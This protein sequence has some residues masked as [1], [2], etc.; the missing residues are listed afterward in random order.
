MSPVPVID[1]DVHPV[2]RSVHQL[3]PY[4][5]AYWQDFIAG[6]RYPDFRPLYHP[7]HSPI[8][9]RPDAR[10]PQD[11]LAGG[12]VD[13]LCA[14][15]L[16]DGGADAA[17]LHCLYAVQLVRNVELSNV[18]ARAT[19]RWIA[20][21]WLD[22]DPRL[23]ASIVVPM[24]TPRAAVEEIEHWSDDHRFVGV[25]VP[26]L[27]ELPYGR[28][29]YWP[30]W[31]AAA[32]AHLPITLHLGG[33][34]GTAPTSAGWP[35]TY[36]EWYVGQQTAVADQLT[37]LIAGGVFTNLPDLT[38]VCAEAGFAWVPAHMWRIDKQWKSFRREVP[39]VLGPPSD[40]LR[41]Q[42]RFTVAPLDG[43]SHQRRFQ[44]TVER[45]GSDEMLL[46]ASDY[47]HWH[48]EP[49]ERLSDAAGDMS[50]LHK[51]RCTNPSAAYPAIGSPQLA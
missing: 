49:P 46:W 16:D 34:D 43:T 10:V 22:R 15:V 18:L 24:H 45:L 32:A 27:S 25:L 23:R 26:A 40:I 14:D 31:Q 5:D 39:W 1:C 47:P 35:S 9:S 19:N 41:R 21:E 4:L 38:V 11:G 28:E 8:A 51:I 17:I 30:V 7:E 2:V 50:L 6:S 33:G 20:E 36:L 13:E 12:S 44:Q 29:I 3:T 48:D 42:V 37:S